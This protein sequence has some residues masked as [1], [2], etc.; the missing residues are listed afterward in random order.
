MNQSTA[1]IEETCSQFAIDP[2]SAKSKRPT[3][4]FD[5]AKP[6]HAYM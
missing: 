2:D 1:V 3:G 5:Q 4:S 6:V